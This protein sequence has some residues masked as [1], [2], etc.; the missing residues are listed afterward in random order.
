MGAL[1]VEIEVDFCT[2]CTG[3]GSVEVGLESL[4]FI[5]INLGSIIMVHP[6]DLL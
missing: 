3:K 1:A 2:F 6:F 4:L 5:P